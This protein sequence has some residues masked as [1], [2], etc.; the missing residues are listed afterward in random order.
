M[1]FTFSHPFIILP[2]AKLEKGW[3][4]LTGLTV[5]SIVPDFEYFIRMDIKSS[6]GHTLGGLFYFDFP[7]GILLCFVFHN[8][9][10][11][12][13]IK[14]LPTTWQRK[15]FK[16]TYF[17]WNSFFLRNWN[18]VLL[19]LFIGIVSHFL[20]DSFTNKEGFFVT[21]IPFLKKQYVYNDL[22]LF[23][24]Q[25]LYYIISVSGLIMIIYTGWQMPAHRRVRPSK[26]S[27]SYWL[28]IVMVTIGSFFLFVHL[29]TNDYMLSLYKAFFANFLIIAITSFIVGLFLT[30]LIF[31]NQGRNKR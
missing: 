24:H 31:I 2:F 15:F 10:R 17:E 20:L 23:F 22:P 9:I 6:H 3:V 25:I 27:V 4:S 7:L 8:L 26:P 30:S 16:F 13:L 28:T 18:L 14:N 1:P 29:K 12:S 19:S 5:G 21:L 11:N